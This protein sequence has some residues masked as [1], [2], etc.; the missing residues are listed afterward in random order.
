MYHCVRKVYDIIFLK[1]L[2][3]FNGVLARG[4]LEPSY[5]CMNFFS[6]L[7]LASVNGKQHLTEVGFSALVG[8]SL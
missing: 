3:A 7:S 8:F 5:A 4:G 1:N 6:C 2:V